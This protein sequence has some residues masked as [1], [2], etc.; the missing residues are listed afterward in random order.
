MHLQVSR[1]L[2]KETIEQSSHRIA[3][4]R[5]HRNKMMGNKM[6]KLTKLIEDERGRR[7]F[8]DILKTDN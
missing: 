7:N 6:E 3:M 8:A 4:I 2:L 1:T 5:N